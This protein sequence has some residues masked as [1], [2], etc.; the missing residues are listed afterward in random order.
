[1]SFNILAAAW[2]FFLII[3]LVAFY[4]LK[5]RRTRLEISSLVLWQ[6]VLQDSRVNSP[7]QKFKK[8]LLLLLQLLLLCLLIFAAM[9]PFILGKSSGLKLPVLVDCS[10]SMGA[11]D[12]KGR[13]RLD[14]VKAK[15]LKLVENKKDAQEIAIIS[16]AKTAKRECSFTSNR[17][18]L[19][20]VIEK[21][22]VKDLEGELE[23]A[24]KVTQAM[25]KSSKF[26]EVLL[27][28]DG[29][30]KDVPTFNLSFKL[31]YQQIGKEFLANLG[32]TRLSARRA[33]TSNWMVFVQLDSTAAYK[34]SAQ[35]EIYQDGLKIGT[36]RV[37][38]GENGRERI[39]FRVDGS[40][41]SLI[42]VRLIPG[43]ADSMKSDNNAW[44]NLQLAR[45][46]NVYV[47]DNNEAVLKI[48]K[49]IA[50]LNLVQRDADLIDL[51]ITDKQED[52][53]LTSTCMLTFGVIP[54]DLRQYFTWSEEQSR[55]ID[56]ERSDLLLQHVSLKDILMLRSLNYSP[57]SGQSS[58]EKKSYEIITFGEK[59]PV[60]VKKNFGDSTRYSF[61]FHYQQ[62]TLPYKVAFPILLTNMVNKALADS[63]LSEKTGNK[64]GI[65]P[66]FLLL[67]NTDYEV[68]KPDGKESVKSNEFG[69]VNG[70]AA[71]VSGQYSFKKGG[72]SVEETSVSLLSTLETRL[73]VLDSVKFN[74]VTVEIATEEA[75]T[76]KPL[77][78][79]LA[80]IA[81]A[82]LL[83]EWW[84]YQKRPGR[85]R[86][87]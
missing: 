63:G 40:K 59:A 9:D 15:L 38:P 45:P 2:F 55:I 70:I 47:A 28:T 8:N 75:V 27:Y 84:F 60:A 34:D 62:S 54:D 85:L 16:Y 56:W 51:V 41:P 52:A 31:N 48:L 25:T 73:E 87:G 21:L 22:Q 6:Q 57:G 80:A 81:F 20:S 46:L 1:M 79:M 43:G 71:P 36:E 65:L 29:N 10:A 37:L 42:E 32:I 82:L 44:L 12:D 30:V 23:E 67:P 53:E 11:A 77:W 18:V 39:S 17:Q 68:I 83:L 19:K 50:G 3:P 5:L 69:L 26:G 13:T 76:D 35:L 14:A 61:F 66:E 33:G 64:T 78:P 86:T 24:L 7:F 4:F 49:N 58:I 72:T 74:E